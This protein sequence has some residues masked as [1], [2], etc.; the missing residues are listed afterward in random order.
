[1]TENENEINP[2][3]TGEPSENDP[4]LDVDDQAPE[5][6]TTGDPE[7]GQK[8]E[9]NADDQEVTADQAPVDPEQERRV[10]E[11]ERDDPT[12]TDETTLAGMVN[13]LAPN[14][15]LE[16]YGRLKGRMSQNL[17]VATALHLIASDIQE[18][19]ED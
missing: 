11:V 12:A 10:A 8:A 4:G 3:N 15:K 14:V 13:S 9:V 16:L 6:E 17:P 2:V 19:L 7:V 18:Y 1:M 5:E